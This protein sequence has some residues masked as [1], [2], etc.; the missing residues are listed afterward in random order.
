MNQASLPSERVAHAVLDRRHD[1]LGNLNE[2]QTEQGMS[3]MQP[4]V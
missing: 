4:E 3:R 1:R 2:Q